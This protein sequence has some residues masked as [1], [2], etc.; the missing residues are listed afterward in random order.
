MAQ[1]CEKARKHGVWRGLGAEQ[2]GKLG[3]YQI[4]NGNM[5][6][7]I[8]DSRLAIDEGLSRKIQVVAA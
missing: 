2:T 1:T 4:S 8:H 7:G 6:I 3:V 5:I